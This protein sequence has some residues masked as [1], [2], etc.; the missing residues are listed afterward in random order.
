MGQGPQITEYPLLGV[1]PDGAGVHNDHV[2]PLGFLGDLIAALAQQ[3]PE[4]LGVGFVLLAAVGLHIGLGGPPGL[5][6]VIFNFITEGVLGLQLFLRNN[7]GFGS[8]EN[9]SEK[10][11]DSTINNSSFSGTFQEGSRNFAVL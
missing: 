4:G 6:P 7:G 11:T 9:S 2:R 5:V 10:D 8:H 3:A 1:L